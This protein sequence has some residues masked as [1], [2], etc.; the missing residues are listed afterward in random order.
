MC[1]LCVCFLCVCFLCV[2]ITVF[3]AL[4]VPTLQFLV[5]IHIY[6]Y[7]L[8]IRSG[9]FVT[10]LYYLSDPILCIIRNNIEK[11]SSAYPAV[12]VCPKHTLCLDTCSQSNTVISVSVSRHRH[13]S[14]SSNYCS[15]EVS[16]T[17]SEI[18][19]FLFREPRAINVKHVVQS[20][21][22]VRI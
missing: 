5:C 18:K 12:I 6:I 19:K 8:H 7:T 15:L 16:T 21:K 1:V 22:R 20:L 3:P 14:S 11:F 9:I 2:Y 10:T 4:N 13:S 17:D